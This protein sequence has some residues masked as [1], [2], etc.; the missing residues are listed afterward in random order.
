MLVSFAQAFTVS[1]SVP[2]LASENSGEFERL[3][4]CLVRSSKPSA[5]MRSCKRIWTFGNGSAGFA[6]S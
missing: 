4:V 1:C 3:T 5:E 2:C 6:E